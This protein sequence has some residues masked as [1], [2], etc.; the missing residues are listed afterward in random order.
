MR[1]GFFLLSK[2]LFYHV[3]S[4]RNPPKRF[5]STSP[6]PASPNPAAPN[7]TSPEG[8]SR[9]IGT[10]EVRFCEAGFGDV[11]GYP[12][13]DSAR[14]LCIIFDSSLT[15]SNHIYCCLNLASSP[16]VIFVESETLLTT[17]YRSYHCPC[18]HSIQSRLLQLLYFL[19]SLV[20]N[21]IAFSSFST[22]PLE[23]FQELLGSLISHLFLNPS[24]GST[25]NNTSN[26]KF[27]PSQYTKH[28]C[29][30]TLI[31]FQSALL[32]HLL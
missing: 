23:Q 8:G 15:M 4:C 20:L 22:S 25:C 1:R 32:V 29:L 31:S 5:I 14:N 30:K 24:S 21:L 7:P 3:I 6:N 27:S 16:F 10:C 11:G 2:P 12:S 17:L 18:F 13:T 9:F 19:I 26:T 28:S